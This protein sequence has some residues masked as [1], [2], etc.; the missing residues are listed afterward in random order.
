MV[1]MIEQA[2]AVRGIA[3]SKRSGDWVLE[4]SRNGSSSR[5][6]GAE[7]GFNDQSAVALAK[8]K[9]ATTAVLENVGLRHVP[10]LLVRSRGDT[11]YRHDVLDALLRN[12][13][14]VLKPLLGGSG[15]LV[16]LV[17]TEDEAVS[18]MR[19]SQDQ[20]W[21]IS[22]HIDAEYELR[23]VILDDEILLAHK[24]TNPVVVSGLKL[25]NLSKGALAEVI[26]VE[27]VE[28]HIAELA[29]TAASAL[30]LRLA[31]VDVLVGESG[32]TILEVNAAFSLTHF[33]KTNPAAY[34]QAAGVYDR[35]IDAMF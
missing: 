30:R 22:P 5:I 1:S 25:F 31:A 16:Q 11:T 17:E 4:L 24:K 6:V 20:G 32:V 33:A 15:N 28:E 26:E 7:F 29:L 2:C 14:G 27:D 18:V 9:V 8:D 21:A 19:A 10:H 23:V 3:L 13:R 12:G 35:L 34:K